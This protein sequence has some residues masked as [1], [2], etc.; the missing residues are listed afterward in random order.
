LAR[1]EK[2]E[3]AERGQRLSQME[4]ERRQGLEALAETVMAQRMV[5]AF[6]SI[7]YSGPG[8]V[9]WAGQKVERRRRDGLRNPWARDIWGVPLDF[10]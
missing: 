8:F 3:A 4:T 10:G 9:S 7:V 5:R 6:P 2:A 1:V